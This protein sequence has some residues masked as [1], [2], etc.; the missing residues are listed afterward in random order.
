MFSLALA[1]CY[2]IFLHH[3]PPSQLNTSGLRFTPY[4]SI[5]IR[6]RSLYPIHIRPPSSLQPLQS[7]SNS[8]S[9]LR[10]SPPPPPA[11]SPSPPPLSLHRPH[12]ARTFTTIKPSY[13]NIMAILDQKNIK[14]I[15]IYKYFILV[16]GPKGC[17]SFYNFLRTYQL[18]LSQNNA[19]S[20]PNKITPTSSVNNTITLNDNPKY[21][22]TLLICH[23]CHIYIELVSLYY[24][25]F[26]T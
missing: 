15:Q 14:R 21:N 18:F 22:V 23:C 12:T 25:L 19:S 6:Y 11:S 5:F 8:L 17:N 3:Y 13:I 7:L 24:L 20:F 1:A 4:V 26:Y 16:S 9:P 2:C 10:S